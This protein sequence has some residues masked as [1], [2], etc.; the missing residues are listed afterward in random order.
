[1]VKQA[2]SFNF[3]I[4]LTYLTLPGEQKTKEINYHN[5]SFTKY[6]GKDTTPFQFKIIEQLLIVILNHRRNIYAVKVNHQKP[7]NSTEKGPMNFSTVIYQN[8]I[9]IPPPP[10]PIETVINVT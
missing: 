6:A 7:E 1:M 4:N 9:K 5:S 10:P 2:T 3:R 8:R